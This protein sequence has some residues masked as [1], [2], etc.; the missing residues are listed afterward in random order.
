MKGKVNQAMKYGVPVVATPIAV[1]AM[2]AVDGES[3]LVGRTPEEFARKL[4]QVYSSCTLW[5]RLSAGGITNVI[6]FF[7]QES[8]RDKILAAFVSAG[9]PPVHRMVRKDCRRR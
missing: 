6:R 9:V 2:S 1:E 3:C 7:S 4:V 8:A 5:D